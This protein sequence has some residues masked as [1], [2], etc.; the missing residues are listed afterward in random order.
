VP[1][2]QVFKLG[3]FTAYIATPDPAKTHKNAAILYLPDII[4]VYQNSKLIAD[5]FAAQGYLCL[6]I[7]IYN[8]DTLTLNR[9]P[10]FDFP[11]WVAQGTTGDNP[12]TAEVIDKIVVMCIDWLKGEKG[13]KKI[14]AVGYCFGAR[15]IARPSLSCDFFMQVHQ[16]FSNCIWSRILSNLAST[17]LLLITYYHSLCSVTIRLSQSAILH[18]LPTLTKRS[19]PHSKL[20]Y[21]SQPLRQTIYSQ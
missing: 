10:G 3:G 7:D 11:K 17:L 20:H 13:V 16:H 9:P 21:P 12:H 19:L 15:V 14:G 8:G 6:L 1:T 18:I 4:G 2:G 5:D